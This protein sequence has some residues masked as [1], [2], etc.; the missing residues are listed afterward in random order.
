[1]GTQQ[2]S[3]TALQRDVLMLMSETGDICRRAAEVQAFHRLHF[4]VVDGFLYY[5]DEGNELQG[6]QPTAAER[7]TWDRC[8]MK[9]ADSYILRVQPTQEPLLSRVA[10]LV[11]VRRR[12]FAFDNVAL[13]E[14]V[15][16]AWVTDGADAVLYCRGPNEW[17]F[18]VTHPAVHVG[19]SRGE[20]S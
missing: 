16:L 6:R 15:Q 13:G 10:R 3:L 11:D 5:R 8:L 17:R 2:K 14:S 18:V 9:T 1:M 7:L 19:L 4:Q 12:S 20:G